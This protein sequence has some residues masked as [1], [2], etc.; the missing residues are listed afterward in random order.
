[1]D[2]TFEVKLE[3]GWVDFNGYHKG[4]KPIDYV[5]PEPKFKNTIKQTEQEG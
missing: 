2:K 4:I 3:S 1:M 5:M